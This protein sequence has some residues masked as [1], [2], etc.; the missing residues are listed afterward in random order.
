MVSDR[1][2]RYVFLVARRGGPPLSAFAGSKVESFLCC[3][4]RHPASEHPLYKHVTSLRLS[5][6]NVNNRGV[7]IFRENSG[8]RWDVKFKLLFDLPF[9][10]NLSQF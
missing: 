7:L 6:V 3:L 1:R 4:S 2:G 9:S 10:L 5:L 8:L